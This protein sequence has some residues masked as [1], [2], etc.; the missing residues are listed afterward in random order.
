MKSRTLPARGGNVAFGL[1][2][3]LIVVA[4]IF[5]LFFG[6]GGS[7]STNT[8]G[9]A[10]TGT[11]GYIGA[12]GETRKTAKA[13]SFNIN[14]QQIGLLIA[15]YRDTN[16]N[17]PRT[18]DDIDA[19]PSMKVDPWGNPITFTFDEKPGANTIRVIYRSN[20]P[21]GKPGTSDD[22]TVTGEIPGG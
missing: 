4:I 15:Q 7:S 17:L 14:T 8:G 18:F 22:Q 1:I 10:S 21:D 20:G 6:V 19:P 16:K 11:G 3:L 13:A 5:F 9:S 12:V 2:A